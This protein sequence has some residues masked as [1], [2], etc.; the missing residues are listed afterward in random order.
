ME[1]SAVSPSEVLSVLELVAAAVSVS[2]L[3]ALWVLQLLPKLDMC[4]KLQWATYSP[5]LLQLVT[6]SPKLGMYNLKLVTCSHK[7]VTQL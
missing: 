3:V 2:A 7:L 6:Y 4:S 5:Q 1:Q